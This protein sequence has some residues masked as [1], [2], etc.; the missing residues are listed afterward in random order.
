MKSLAIFVALWIAVC[1]IGIPI[2]SQQDKCMIVYSR[3]TEDFLKIDITFSKFP[4]Q[5]DSE[6]YFITLINTETN[7]VESFNVTEGQFR[8]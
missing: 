5:T 8:R 4:G 7:Y 3:I 1:S 6:Y 2:N